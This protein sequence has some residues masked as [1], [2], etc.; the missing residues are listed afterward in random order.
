M[1]RFNNWLKAVLINLHTKPGYSVLD[2][3]CGKGGDLRKWEQ[4]KIT[5][6]VGCDIAGESVHQAAERYNSEKGLCTFQ[7]SFLIGDMFEC[8]ISDYLAEE[9]RF[10]VVSC[11]FAMH[12]AFESEIRVRQLLTNITS[13]LNPGGFFIGTTTDS[14]VIIRKL[15]ATEGLAIGN[16]VFRIQ[17]DDKFASK[18]F[19]KDSPYGIRYSFTLDKKVEDCPEYI[20]HFPTFEKVAREFDLEL[21]LHC[22]FHDFFTEFS[23]QKSYPDYRELMYR[24]RVLDDQGTVP[25]HQWDAIYLYTAFAFKKKGTPNPGE[26]KYAVKPEPRRT[27]HDVE[28]V[29]MRK[30]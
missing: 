15:R 21:V 16:N 4:A 27:V 30:G 18:S 24:M 8:V 11:Q 23:N 17:F 25:V 6:Y 10:D 9:H 3:C 20:V 7:P 28:I 29:V 22:N 5:S 19:P 26:E 13:R 14:N 12:Y 2:L 1:R